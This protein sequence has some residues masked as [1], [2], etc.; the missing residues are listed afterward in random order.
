[1]AMLPMMA[2]RTTDAPAPTI[3]VYRITPRMENHEA[4]QRVKK[5]LNIQKNSPAM[6]EMLKPEMA[7]MWAVPVA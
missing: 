5:R 1:M 7:M 2:A 3:N 4:F 6:M